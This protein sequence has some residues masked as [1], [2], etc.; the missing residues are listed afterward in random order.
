[1]SFHLFVDTFGTKTAIQDVI[2]E[3]AEHAAIGYDNAHDDLHGSAHLTREA[4]YRL[5]HMGEVSSPEATRQELVVAASL[6]VAGIET[7]D[8]EARR[9]E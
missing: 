2:D 6:L 7:I 3:R 1:M 9:V 5:T 4:V 8:R